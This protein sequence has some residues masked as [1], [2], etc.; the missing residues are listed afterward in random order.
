VPA[1]DLAKIETQI[2]DLYA[3]IIK[4]NQESNKKLFS[5]SIF[6]NIRKSLQTI[7]V[8]FDIK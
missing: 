8:F 2:F 4:E 3:E 5:D 6:N 7:L 1:A